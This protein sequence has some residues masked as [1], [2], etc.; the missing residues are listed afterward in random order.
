MDMAVTLAA[1]QGVRDRP[2]GCTWIGRS[3]DAGGQ[4]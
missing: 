4:G 1:N 2:I 3:A